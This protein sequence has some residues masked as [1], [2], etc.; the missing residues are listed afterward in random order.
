MLIGTSRPLND[1]PVTIDEGIY[2]RQLERDYE[3]NSTALG[4]IVELKTI[5]SLCRAAG[6]DEDRIRID[7]SV[8]RGLEYYTGPVYEAE[9]TF[10]VNDENG[11]PV[12]FGS[13]GGGGRY[14]GLVS[15]FRGEPVPATGFSIGVSRL[16]A[17]LKLLGRGASDPAG[18]VVV[19][20]MDKDSD[21]VGRYLSLAATLRSEG[22]P[23]EIYLGAAGVKA[24][25]RYADRRRSPVV[26]IQGSNERAAGEVTVKDLI[27]GARAAG[28]IADRAG[29][30]GERPGQ[31]TVPEAEM[32]TKVKEYLGRHGLLPG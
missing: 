21:S 8:V 25:M 32:V 28:K 19:L 23:A 9:L 26:V 10:Q 18:P 30:I 15:R 4:G 29:W 13:V 24:Q 27:E 12:R 14:D 2:L 11:N 20:V 16:A 31:E 5:V 6:Y 22:I 1:D 3:H 7:P 17:A